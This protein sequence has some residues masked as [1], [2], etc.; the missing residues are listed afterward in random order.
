[1]KNDLQLQIVFLMLRN[2]TDGLRADSFLPAFKG[3]MFRCGGLNIHPI[4]GKLKQRSNIFLHL[5]YIRKQ[6]GFLCNDGHITIGYLSTALF[7]QQ[8]HVLQ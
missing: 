8:H 7:K 4:Q 5:G 1:M 3:K 2:H 6:L